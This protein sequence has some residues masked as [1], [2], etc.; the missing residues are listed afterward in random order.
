[1]LLLLNDQD[2]TCVGIIYTWK[3]F[4]GNSIRCFLKSNEIRPTKSSVGNAVA[5]QLSSSHSKRKTLQRFHYIRTFVA[6]KLE[7]FNRLF[8]PLLEPRFNNIS[9]LLTL[10]LKIKGFPIRGFILNFR[11]M[12]VFCEKSFDFSD[13]SKSFQS[14]MSVIR[15]V[16]HCTW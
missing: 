13:I 12:R 15:R 14:I 16:Y 7:N 8:T 10:F 11:K 5:G 3:Q 2:Y 1:M 4:R 6:R 9:H